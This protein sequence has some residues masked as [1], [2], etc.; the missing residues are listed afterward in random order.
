MFP[1]NVSI[2]Y[3]KQFERGQGQV[4]AGAPAAAEGRPARSGE[5]FPCS[6]SPAPEAL[7]KE[8]SSFGGHS[9]WTAKATPSTRKARWL[10]RGPVPLKPSRQQSP[11]CPC[12]ARLPGPLSPV[13]H[14][15]QAP[16][17]PTRTDAPGGGPHLSPLISLDG[18]GPFLISLLPHSNEAEPIAF[19]CNCI[20]LLLRSLPRT[21]ACRAPRKHRS[22]EKPLEPRPVEGTGSPPRDP[23]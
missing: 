18:S 16:T 12:P 19:C 15:H 13:R 10:C 8:H 11:G 22:L 1:L 21:H 20:F 6:L 17:L 7:V 4:R 14:H 9:T 2:E 5:R 23:G 3:G